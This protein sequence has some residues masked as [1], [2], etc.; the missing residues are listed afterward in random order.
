MD[1][2]AELA[3]LTLGL[4]TPTQCAA[5]LERHRSVLQLRNGSIGLAG[6]RQ[7]ASRQHAR[8]RCLDRRPHFLSAGHRQQ[9][10]FSRR[11]GVPRIEIDRR[12]RSIGPGDR[13]RKLQRRGPGPSSDCCTPRIGGAVQR[14]PTER[15]RLK[16]MRPGAT[17]DEHQLFAS[18]GTNEQVGRTLRF[19]RFE[20]RTGEVHGSLS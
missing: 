13:H 9:R 20:K 6:F 11:R 18:C 2:V 16:V 1:A 12:R 17:G 15:E 10:L 5:G 14:K 4:V 8:E 7:S 3:Q 19:P